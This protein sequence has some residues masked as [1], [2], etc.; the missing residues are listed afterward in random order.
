MTGC[1]S[2]A[3]RSSRRGSRAARR[4]CKIVEGRLRALR[5]HGQRSVRLNVVLDPDRRRCPTAWFACRRAPPSIEGQTFDVPDFWMDRFEV[6]NRQFK[7][8]VDAGGYTNAR[9]LEGAVHRER[10][11]ALVGGGDGAVPRPH[12]PSRASTWELGTL[13]RRDRRTFRSA[14]VSWY[15]AAAF[16]VFAGKSL[17]TAFQW[18]RPRDFDGPSGVYRRHPAAQ[19]LRRQGAGGRRLATRHR[20]RTVSTTWPAT[21]RSGAGTNRA[22]AG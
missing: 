12:R 2:A 22:A 13:S 17:P 5:R 18:R 16:A 9:V 1:R 7:A 8:F 21:S 20:R 4:A 11:H 6:T 14:G 3:R 15:E 19:Q 10:P